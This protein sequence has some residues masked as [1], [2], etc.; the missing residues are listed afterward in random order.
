MISLK[1]QLI[2]LACLS[3]ICFT[4]IV[5]AEYSFIPPTAEG[6]KKAIKNLPGRKRKQKEIAV[7]EKS[8]LPVANIDAEDLE[9]NL[10]EPVFSQGVIQT[11]KGGVITAEGIRI[12]A[13]KIQYT[14]KI[15]NGVRILKIVAEGDLMMEFGERIF[16]GDKLEFD[17]ITKTGTLWNGRTDVDVWFLGGE[18]IELQQDGSFFIY[19]AFI[20]TCES[21]DNIWEIN[22][23]SVKISKEHILS[24]RNIKFKFFKVP[25]FWFPAFKSNLKL[26][27]DSPIKYNVV[28]DKGLGPRATL[29]YRV[30]SWQDLNLFLRLDYRLN[31]GF[32]GA[33]ESEYYSPDDRTVFITRSYAAH[34]KIVPE[35]R[36]P[37][38]YRLQ[39]LLSHQS[40]DKK[41]F[42]HLQYD[43]FSDLQMIDDFKS[44]D[45]VIDTQKRTRLLIN[46]QE[47]NVFGTLSLQPQINRF[48][49]INEQLPL[50][51]L[52]VRPFT[53]GPSG[54]ISENFV[55]AGF[56][57]YVF[58]QELHNTLKPTHAARFETQNRLYRPIH[59]GPLTLTPTIG[60]VGI[61]Y[62]NNPIHKDAGQLVFSYGGELNTQLF[63]SY[64]RQT[65]RIEPYLQ[66]T[67]L[68]KPRVN[69][70]DHFTFSMDDGYYKLNQLRLGTR[71]YFFSRKESL[72]LPVFFIDVYTNTYF[73]QDRYTR[74]F[75]KLYTTFVWNRP[76]Y[77]LIS[78]IAWNFQEQVLDFINTR[79]DITINEHFAFG[80]EYRYRSQF[81][82]RKANH[83][84]FILDMAHSIN[85]LLHS[86]LS[87]R[88]DT[89]LSRVQL[90]ISPKWILHIESVQGWRRKKDPFYSAV[91]TTVTTML[92]CNWQLKFGYS[93]TPDDDRFTT[94]VQLAK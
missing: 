93:H 9:I 57:K 11:D 67:G 5:Q 19:N 35:E 22:S 89:I 75:P 82:W 23:E 29:R 92:P 4:S 91:K 68:T 40:L 79:T 59:M 18:K 86:P 51:T 49:S 65:H 33:L 70:F 72:L 73:F 52:G 39:G 61:F 55:N 58:A 16:V 77:A 12:Q 64:T 71:N 45:F 44:S 25:V 31:R 88:R 48:E 27:S 60:A 56:L 24:A 8:P 63:K 66:Y 85:S 69:N 90:R 36:G 3:A 10:V 78:D 46:H 34:D 41:T 30:L 50:V 2:S 15:E 38:R 7:V 28:W 43:K 1:K 84:N 6:F 87:D 80:L 14:N 20:T 81:D 94:Q 42:L 32:G 13:Q 74:T 47:S 83:D 21:Q 76:T 17:F 62:N 37:R 54:I 26:F 53:L